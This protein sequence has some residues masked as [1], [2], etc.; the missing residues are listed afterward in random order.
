MT[1]YAVR[2]DELERTSQDNG[3]IFVDRKRQRLVMPF[4]LRMRHILN[5][6]RSDRAVR[7]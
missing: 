1:G 6:C 5:I 7:R 2:V 4:H 3:L